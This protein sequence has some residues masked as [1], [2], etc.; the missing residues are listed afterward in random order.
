M[1]KIYFLIALIFLS[2]NFEAKGDE[3]RI[4]FKIKNKV[5]T[6]IDLENRKKYTEFIGNNQSLNEEVIKKDY[7]SANIFNEYFINSNRNNIDLDQNVLQV[8]DNI[9][10]ENEKNKRIFDFVIKKEI[11]LKN[12]KID[13]IRKT[14]LEDLINSEKDRIVISKS[15]RDLLYKYE[16]E[17]INIKHNNISKIKSVIEEFKI[18]KISDII[19]ILEIDKENYF[20]KKK[21]I[22]NLNSINSKIKDNI[23]ANEF[24]RRIRKHRSRK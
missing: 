8:F 21:E 2:L 22:N 10:N 19:K 15:D 13:L 11:I 4:L 24:L 1:N 3:N 14:I 9:N 23:L 7:I 20:I 17:Y 16:I 5:F 18:N 6:S 12:L